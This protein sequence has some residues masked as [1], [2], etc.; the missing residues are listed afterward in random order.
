MEGGA[1]GWKICSAATETNSSK[2]CLYCGNF[3]QSC[4]AMRWTTAQ[5][6]SIDACCGIPTSTKLLCAD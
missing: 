3:A 6:L 4:D 5:S 2:A 1:A